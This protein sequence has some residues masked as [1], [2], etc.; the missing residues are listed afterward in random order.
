MRNNLVAPRLN[1]KRTSFISHTLK[2]IA[3][4]YRAV[5]TGAFCMADSRDDFQGF[6]VVVR[7]TSE[8]SRTGDGELMFNHQ[9]NSCSCPRTQLY[10][11]GEIVAFLL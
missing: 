7:A 5:I 4:D 1:P 8:S 9:L 6:V 11:T 2:L 3:M 10:V